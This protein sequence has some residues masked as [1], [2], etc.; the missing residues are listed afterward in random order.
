MEEL[1]QKIKDTASKSARCDEDYNAF[2]D[3]DGNFDDA[4]SNGL[5]DGEILFARELLDI[6][7]KI[8]ERN[9]RS[10]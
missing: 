4:Y 9:E 1:L 10:M 8:I 6:V 2:E 7:N 3:S 5:E